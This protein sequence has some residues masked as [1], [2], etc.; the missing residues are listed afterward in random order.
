[1]SD[2]TIRRLRNLELFRGCNRSE[3]EKI[4]Q[5]TTTLVFRAGKTLCTEGALAHEFFVLVDGVA[6]L[7][8]SRGEAALL[9]PGTWFG[10]GA[11]INGAHRIATVTTVTDTMVLVFGRREFRT[12]CTDVP[13]VLARIERRRR[14]VVPYDPVLVGDAVLSR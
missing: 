4:D 3:L 1:M 13:T 2:I 14:E 8:S 5:L 10:E 11:L 12:L 9:G 6:N 7:H